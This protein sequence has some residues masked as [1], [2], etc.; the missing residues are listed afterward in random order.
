[1]YLQGAGAATF[2]SK[3]STAG[4]NR[5]ECSRSRAGTDNVYLRDIKAVC[6]YDVL[7]LHIRKDLLYRFNSHLKRKYIVS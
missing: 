3:S 4:R 5:R 1:M 2:V 6:F 7:R